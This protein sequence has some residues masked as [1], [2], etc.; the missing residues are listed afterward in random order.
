MDAGASEEPDAC[1]S[2]EL[3]AGASEGP[4][5][6]TSEETDPGMS[7]EPDAGTLE[8]PD[9]SAS[10]EQDAGVSEETDAGVLEER[11]TLQ[12]EAKR[13]L[14]SLEEEV[15]RL[16]T[17][18][19]QKH[20]EMEELYLDRRMCNPSTEEDHEENRPRFSL[21]QKIK[22]VAG[23]IFMGLVTLVITMTEVEIIPMVNQD[24][25]ICVR[26]QF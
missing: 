19:R 3:D 15:E 23:G 6:G 5:A 12:D 24:W 1:A 4:D 13:K 22:Y 9:A 10:E 7:E 18:L 11:D 8:E 16:K 17:M 20:D 26:F 14:S 2:E 21:W 25:D